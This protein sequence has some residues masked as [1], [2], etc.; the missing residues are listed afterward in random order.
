MENR[1]ENI[2]FP[3]NN[4]LASHM[5]GDECQATIES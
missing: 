2:K 5:A 3:T 1:I 4:I